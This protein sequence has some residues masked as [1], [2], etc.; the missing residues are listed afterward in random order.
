MSAGL[1][2]PSFLLLCTGMCPSLLSC[3][4][5]LALGGQAQPEAFSLYCSRLKNKDFG[6]VLGSWLAWFPTLVHPASPVEPYYKSTLNMPLETLAVTILCPVGGQRFS[7]CILDMAQDVSLEKM[8]QHGWG[9][10]EHGNSQL[11]CVPT[12]YCWHGF[13]CEGRIPS[14]PFFPS[15]L[16]PSLSA[17]TGEVLP[18]ACR[19][20]TRGLIA[21]HWGL[22]PSLLGHC[23]NPPSQSHWAVLSICSPEMH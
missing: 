20:R 19:F 3:T 16:P 9:I 22:C 11:I 15:L 23:K 12:E 13:H 1:S 7:G 4:P 10:D 2:W 17:C 21:S 6:C 14:P 8:V 18:V 5:L